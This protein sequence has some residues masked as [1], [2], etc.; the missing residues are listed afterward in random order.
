MAK[1]RGIRVNTVMDFIAMRT[2]GAYIQLH[3]IL[4]HI[5]VH[6]AFD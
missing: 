3:I 4:I 1:A 2:L 5:Y 6:T